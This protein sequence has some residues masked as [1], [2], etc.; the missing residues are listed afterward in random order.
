MYK[1]LVCYGNRWAMDRKP[2][3]VVKKVKELQQVLAKLQ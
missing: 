3:L 2:E 1:A